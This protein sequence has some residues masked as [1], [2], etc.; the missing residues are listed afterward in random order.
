[1]HNGGDVRKIGHQSLQLWVVCTDHDHAG[2][3]KKRPKTKSP[4]LAL[5]YNNFRYWAMCK[6]QRV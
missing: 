3:N 1:L 6:K 4:W 5:M 2:L